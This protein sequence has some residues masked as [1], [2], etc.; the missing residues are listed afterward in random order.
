MYRSDVIYYP[1]PDLHAKRTTSF[2][3]GKRSD[4]TSGSKYKCQEQYNIKS[5]FEDKKNGIP[6]YSFGISRS[7]YEKVL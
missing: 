6:A 1:L 3:Y 2:G 7:F 4:F 5:I